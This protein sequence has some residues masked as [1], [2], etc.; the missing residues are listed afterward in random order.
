[1][2]CIQIFP[3]IDLELSPTNTL[4]CAL[5]TNISYVVAERRKCL[6]NHRVNM[7]RKSGHQNK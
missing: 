5:Y 6:L 2:Y 1:M 7:V 3:T 4:C